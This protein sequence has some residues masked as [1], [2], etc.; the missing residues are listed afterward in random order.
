ME[1]YGAILHHNGRIVVV[2]MSWSESLLTSCKHHRIYAV[3]YYLILICWHTATP[4]FAPEPLLWSIRDWVLL[5]SSFLLITKPDGID[6]ELSKQMFMLRPVLWVHQK[7]HALVFTKDASLCNIFD[8][9][10]F[11]DSLS[12]WYLMHCFIV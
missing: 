11:I 9:F 3:K 6:N 8:T 7:Y 2:L 5:F 10:L 4:I 1:K 12:V